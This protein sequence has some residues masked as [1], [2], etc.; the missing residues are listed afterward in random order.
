MTTLDAPGSLQFTGD[1]FRPGASDTYRSTPTRSGAL[2]FPTPPTPKEITGW[3]DDQETWTRVLRDR[4]EADYS[5]S[6]LDPFDAGEGYQS[7]TSNEPKVGFI[8]TS[9]MLSDATLGIRL[10]VAKKLQPDRERQDAKER[11]LYGLLRANDERL[12]NIGQPPLLSAMAGFTNLRGIVCGRALLVKDLLS[13]GTYPDITPWD[14]LHTTWAFGARGLKWICYKT[15]KTVEEIEDEYEVRLSRRDNYQGPPIESGYSDENRRPSGY[16][17]TEG[18]DVYD[19]LDETYS[20]VVVGGEY[21]K[22]PTLHGSPRTPAFFSAVG[23]LPLIQSLNQAGQGRVDNL[24][25]YGESIFEA[26]RSI[27]KK[28]N[29]V[30]STMLQLVALSRNQ[31][32]SYTSRDGTKRL[33]DNPSLEGSQVPLAEGER[34]DILPLLEMAKDTGAFLGIITSE[35][36][37]GVLPYSSYG[38]LMFQLSGYAVDLLSTAQKTTVTPRKQNVERAILQICNLLSDQYA[39]RGFGSTLSLSG[40]DT[41]RDWFDEQ[42]TPEMIMG[43]GSPVIT[44]TVESPQDKLQ[45]VQMAAMLK[46]SRLLPDRNIRDEILNRQDT[47]Q[48]SR[49]L[50]EQE[51]E[52]MLPAAKLYGLG[53]SAFEMGRRDLAMIYLRAAAMADVTGSLGQLLGG[54][55]GPKASG[56][57]PEVLSAPEQGAATPQPTPQGGPNV[58]PGSPR[59]GARTTP[60]TQAWGPV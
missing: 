33:K 27:Y 48:I 2:S 59:P 13:G 16:G 45:R 37:R 44:L 10:P 15:K 49:T 1:G 42:F 7:Y 4:M 40:Q 14:P 28:V 35:L 55:Q 21:V 24:V 50:K 31:A 17:Y 60:V 8:K 29:L 11:F 46:E 9:T 57:S 18:I 26:N 54:G 12:V 20:C 6:V 38:Q 19:W 23:F 41:N 52:E 56:F 51:A 32:F 3:V 53:L 47:D 22:P 5:M 30:L 25:H 39:S 43:L 36:Q 34:L 58:P